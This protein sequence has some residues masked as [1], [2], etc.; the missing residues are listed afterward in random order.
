M[1]LVVGLTADGYPQ[2]RCKRGTSPLEGYHH[3]LR[4]IVAQSCLSPKLLVSLLRSFNY[5]WN[6]NMAVENGDLPSFYRDFY[7]HEKVEEVQVRL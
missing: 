5:R 7:C 1:L 2:Y 3:H 4:L 6:V